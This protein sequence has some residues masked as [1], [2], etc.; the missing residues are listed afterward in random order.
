[1]ITCALCQQPKQPKSN[2]HYVTDFLIRT[3]LNEDGVNFKNKGLY[4]SFPID[5]PFLDFKYQQSSRESIE[6]VLGREATEEENEEARKTPD[7]SIDNIFCKDCEDNFGVVESAFSSRLTKKFRESDLTGIS[8][9]ILTEEE[10]KLFRM[11]F[12]IQIWRTSVCEPDFTIS[13]DMA[14]I[15]RLKILNQDYT[16]LE[17]FPLSVYYLE[18]LKDEDDE[19]EGD[20]Y[21]T[22]NMV[23]ITLGE[24]PYVLLLND[25]VV[26]FYDTDQYQFEDVKGFF[27]ED[28]YLEY[29]NVNE[30]SFKVKVISNTQ[31]REILAGYFEGE[32]HRL[33]V[34]RGLFPVLFKETFGMF[35][36]IETQNAFWKEF[37]ERKDLNLLSQEGFGGLVDDFCERF[38]RANG[39]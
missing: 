39:R 35:P 9:I 5:T 34:L 25:F 36:T 20:G 4:W 38:A 19:S 29:L 15:L 2:T 30:L 31:R 3:A 28:D 11:F 24:N 13:P 37:V 14:E 23:G 22:E 17:K 33:E 8:E 26:S 6:K 21:K 27:K 7:F 1:M 16:D 12:L 18:T 10:S 32:L